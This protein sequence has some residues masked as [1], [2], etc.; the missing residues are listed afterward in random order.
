MLEKK[1]SAMT[2]SRWFTALS[3]DLVPFL[4]VLNPNMSL[5]AGTFKQRS[6]G[7]KT[8]LRNSKHVRGHDS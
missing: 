3:V 1:S 2:Q 7:I 6:A 5:C 4:S 8:E